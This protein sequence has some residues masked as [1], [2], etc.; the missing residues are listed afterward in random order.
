MKFKG[1]SRMT[2]AQWRKYTDGLKK[3]DEKVVPNLK[4]GSH[5]PQNVYTCSFYN[6]ETKKYDIYKFTCFTK[7]E[8]RGMLKE[9]VGKVPVGTVLTVK[10]K[11]ER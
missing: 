7:S 4:V 11:H 8:A 5:R 6:Q 9:I 1:P 10:G 3:K 2:L